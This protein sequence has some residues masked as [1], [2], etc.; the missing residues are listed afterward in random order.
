MMKNSILALLAIVT[1]FACEK[2]IYLDV[3]QAEPVLVI[4]ANVT[5]QLEQQVVKLSKSSTFGVTGKTPRVSGAS[6]EVKDN[7]NNGYRFVEKEPGVYR[8]EQAFA[9]IAGRTYTLLVKAEGK[10]YT[11]SEQMTTNTPIDSLTYHI[12]EQEM[13]KPK[14]PD[15]FYE[16]LLYVQEP[17]AT[18]DYYL[19][20]F[21]R[22]GKLENDEGRSV[23]IS[24]DKIL[25][26]QVEGLKFPL[27]FAANDEAK[28]EIIH[29]TPSAYKFYSDLEAS[30]GNDGGVFSGQPANVY[31][32]ISGGARGYF[33]VAAVASGSLRVVQ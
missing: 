26:G 4:E 32:N 15:R 12:D 17:Q 23:F 8:S 14:N 31:T 5:N 21:Y 22:N 20:Q 9:G 25:N 16:V 7:F 33:L 6:V 3:K 19:F 27:F 10:T 28:I 11:A 18:V 29:I 1:L 24:D 30:I 13:Q 2:T